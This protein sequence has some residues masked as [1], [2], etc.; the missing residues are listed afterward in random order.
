MAA[1]GLGD[2]PELGSVVG[3]RAL[4]LREVLRYSREQ[5][6]KAVRTSTCLLVERLSTV[7]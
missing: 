2:P 5:G 1:A 3:W 7:S 4:L 6:L